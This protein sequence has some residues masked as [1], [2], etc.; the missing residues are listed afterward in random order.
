M[1][2]DLERGKFRDSVTLLTALRGLNIS[3]EVS[4][5]RSILGYIFFPMLISTS[6][7]EC[8]IVQRSIHRG[9]TGLVGHSGAL[10][11]RSTEYRI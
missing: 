5:A 2:M 11:Y 3:D 4:E 7:F 1:P 6:T 8:M 10:K 9:L